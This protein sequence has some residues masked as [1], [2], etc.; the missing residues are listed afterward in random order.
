[1]NVPLTLDGCAGLVSGV[2]FHS[3]WQGALLA[4]IAAILLYLLPRRR[5]ALR[6]LIAYFHLFL[7][8]VAMLWTT[9]VLITRTPESSAD[10][11]RLTEPSSVPG[12][13]VETVSS[14][15]SPPSWRLAENPWIVSRRRQIDLVLASAW[16]AGV[17]FFLIRLAGAMAGIR[18][19]RRDSTPARSVEHAKLLLELR[20]RAGT[21]LNVRLR[22]SP[23]I[24]SPLTLGFFQPLILLPVSLATSAPPEH[25]RAALAHELMHIRHGDYLLNF[26]QHLIESLMFFHP[27]VWWLSRRIREEREIRCDLR[28]ASLLENPRDYCAALLALEER[29]S[30]SSSYHPSP[31]LAPAMRGSDGS[32]KN[33]IRLLL[34]GAPARDKAL[35]PF[36][37]LPVLLAM[38]LLSMVVFGYLK[39]GGNSLSESSAVH[40]AGSIPE[41]TFRDPS[42][43]MAQAAAAL[44]LVKERKAAWP[45]TARPLFSS[46]PLIEKNGEIIDLRELTPPCFPGFPNHWILEHGLNPLASNLPQQDADGDGFS[47][48]EEYRAQTSPV[49]ATDHPSL[50]NKLSFVERRSK[51][52]YALYEAHPS[53]DAAQVSLTPPGGS[54]SER[55]IL[56]PGTTTESRRLRLDSVAAD[57]AVVTWLETSRQFTLP[58]GKAIPIST[59]Y[60]ELRFSPG[61]LDE[62]FVV[63]EGTAFS[64]P[65]H[66]DIR[67]RLE[68]ITES[69]AFFLDLTAPDGTEDT[70]ETARF[71]LKA[72]GQ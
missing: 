34:D 1:M 67:L 48:L 3:L 42:A 24:D 14:L 53:D 22:F 60:A 4:A 46:V 9:A 31:S 51:T 15:N 37:L 66:P 43:N 64:L 12:D 49:D 62:T 11:T 44:S 47:N 61:E 2:L 45:S 36:A 32:L 58:K 29:R 27:A 57:T 35:I 54:R 19:L 65:E 33:R 72:Q 55:G 68:A 52:W 6:H 40:T 17:L 70:K 63:K 21:S 16:L 59:H 39:T 5:A 7:L 28:A 26:L 13:Q 8:P 50:L 69:E 41:S 20:H 71:S 38:A 18:R 23:T 56:F 30:L 25:L 10:F